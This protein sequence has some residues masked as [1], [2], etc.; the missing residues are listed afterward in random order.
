L[1]NYFSDFPYVNPFRNICDQ[2][3][4]LSEIAPNSEFWT[5]FLPSQIFWDGPSKN[6][7]GLRTL[8]QKFSETPDVTCTEARRYFKARFEL[9]TDRDGF[10]IVLL[11]IWQRVPDLQCHD[12]DILYS[13]LL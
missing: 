12:K 8:K 7:R 11:M 9:I 4:K 2:S 10:T 13:A 6:C 1:I 3:R 5:I